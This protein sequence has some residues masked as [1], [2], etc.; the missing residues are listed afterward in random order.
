[1][2][3]LRKVTPSKTPSRRSVGVWIDHREAV[4]VFVAGETKEL[5]RIASHVERHPSRSE[6]ALLEPRRPRADD[7]RE[8]R[9]TGQL[10]RYYEEVVARVAGTDAVL[11]FG[12]G[13]AKGE[14]R[15]HLEKSGLAGRAVF[16]EAAE[17]MSEGQLLR[18]VRQHFH[19]SLPLIAPAAFA[20]SHEPQH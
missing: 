8:R 10:A 9:F 18:K 15:R 7:S 3:R 5:V 2:P 16:L 4:L 19:L 1:M 20:S 14:L 17:R 11:I 12:P 13:E 6:G